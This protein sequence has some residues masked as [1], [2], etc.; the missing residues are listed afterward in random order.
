MKNVISNVA[1]K[2][3]FLKYLKYFFEKERKFVRKY[4]IQ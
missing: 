4:V 3:T 1:Q 2:N